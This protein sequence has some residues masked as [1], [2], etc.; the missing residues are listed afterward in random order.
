M[1]I[2]METWAFTVGTAQTNTAANIIQ[3]NFFIGL[4]SFMDLSRKGQRCVGLRA[5][6]M[7]KEVALRMSNL[8]ETYA[9][10]A[11]AVGT[12]RVPSGLWCPCSQSAL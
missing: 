4:A 11:P 2:P 7:A 9:T 8:L 10:S 12:Q 1:A 3:I 6:A 5:M